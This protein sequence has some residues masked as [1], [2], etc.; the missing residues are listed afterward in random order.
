VSAFDATEARARELDAEDRL[1]AFRSKFHIPRATDG[2]EKAYF[3]GNSLG[4][5]PVG[6]QA[7]VQRELDAWAREGVDGHFKADAPWYTYHEL[8][9]E[10]LARLTGARPDEV[11]AMNS[12]TV[13]L[14]LLMVTFFRPSPERLKILMEP[15]AFPS[16]T[17]AAR[18]Q[19][20]LAGC[21]PEHGLVVCE[22]RDGRPVLDTEDVLAA[23]EDQGKEIALVLLPGVNHFTGQAFDLARIAKAAHREGCVVGVDLAHAVGN[24]PLKLHDWEIDFA[25]WC[26]YKYLNG[27]PGAVAG[28]FVHERLARRTSL[29]RLGG[30]WGND[31]ATRFR[32]HLEPQ[33]TPRPSAD[34]WQLSNPPILALAPLRASLELFDEA[35]IDPL[36]EKSVQLTG[37]LEAWVEH[38]A[39]PKI[40]ILTAKDPAQRGCQ[41]SLRVLDRPKALFESLGEAGI[42]ADFREPDVIRVAPVPLYNS[43]HDVFRFGQALSAWST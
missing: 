42:V 28:A 30:W 3:A 13:N 20:R 7:L 38:A 14:H 6:A 22:P 10:P 31:P 17:Y 41:L 11:V 15:C 27:G 39:G 24:V 1:A 18:T 12:L 9:R 5:Q 34:G 37:Y 40:E 32:M 23:I 35:G 4:L 43:F 21:D 19:L 36:R 26:S 25:V 16:D 29:P 2:R 8:V 33:F